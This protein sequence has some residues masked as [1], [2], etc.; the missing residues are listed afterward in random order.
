[1]KGTYTHTQQFCSLGVKVQCTVKILNYK[2][3][4][5]FVIF[6]NQSR[7]LLICARIL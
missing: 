6:R 7:I 5:F 3:T 2:Y 4:Q 1:M